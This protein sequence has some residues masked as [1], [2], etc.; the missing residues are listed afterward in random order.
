MVDTNG[1]AGATQA[2]PPAPEVTGQA[3]ELRNLSKTFGGQVVLDR[4]S[5]LVAEGEVHGLVGQNG[6][7]KSTLIKVLAGYHAPDPGASGSV[8]GRSLH[9]GSATDAH[10][11]GVRFVHQD[12]GL[13]LELSAVENLM[14]GRRYPTSMG[15]RIRWRDARRITSELVARA[16]LEID[17]RTPVGELGV[18]DRTRLA[19]A[20][21]LPDRE[22]D[23]VVLVLD[24]PTAALPARDVDRLFGTIRQLK[25]AG[26]S[27]V[28]VSHHLDEI[29]D[30]T[31]TITVLRDGKKVSTAAAS[32]ID[33]EALT[34]LIVGRDIERS[35]G[36]ENAVEVAG[37]A[38]LRLDHLG[39]GSVTDVSAI[40]H[41]GEILGIAGLS[42]SGRE[43]LVS[44]ITGRLPRTGRVQVDG[45]AVPPGS[46]SA[47]LAI[48][49]ASVPGERARFGIFPNLNV[50]QNLTM[51][52]LRRHLRHGHIDAGAERGE[53]RQWI[54]DLGIVTR[55]PDAPITSLSGGNQQKVLVARAL[56]LSPRVL[57]LDDPT[58]GIDVGAREQVHRIVEENSTESMAVLLVSTDSTELA[59]LCD[60]VL[61][62]NRGR[63]G[64]E[65]RRGVDLSADA[66]D[67]A[68]VAV[69]AA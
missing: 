30:I 6:S 29:L 8:H 43:I 69:A 31:D 56:R 20:R 50:R 2:G 46:P 68:Q 58:A 28:I 27:I 48:R 66:I 39:G 18:A 55:S 1:P 19:I 14:L 47:A 45:V 3:L 34:R 13:V 51:G 24:E 22:D 11:L 15:F 41:Q 26:N 16:G 5:L 52:S 21:A 7:G 62:M 65:L 42:G 9:V 32:S 59:R 49:L 54:K 60:R 57:V 64:R 37:Q 38:V 36:R 23:K 4:V 25:E 10:R 40:V 33:H 35:K 44:L 61:I 67:H 63:V 17:V 53:V 12:L